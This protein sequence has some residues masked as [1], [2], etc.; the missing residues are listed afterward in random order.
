MQESVGISQ[1]VHSV[2][3]AY[4]QL[5]SYENVSL[6]QNSQHAGGVLTQFHKR[7][8]TAIEWDFEPLKLPG[9]LANFFEFYP[10]NFLGL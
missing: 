10:K 6:S 5:R 2:K 3:A 9:M 4:L 1:V 8:Q 7:Y